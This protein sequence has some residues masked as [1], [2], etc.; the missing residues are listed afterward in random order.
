MH[1][2]D[3]VGLC[4]PSTVKS[5]D[6]YPAL[7]LVISNFPK[8]TSISPSILTINSVAILFHE[9]GYAIHSILGRTP[10]GSFAGTNVMSD[11]LEVSSQMLEEWMGNKDIL[12]QLSSHYETGDHLPDE[13]LDQLI[14]AKKLSKA[15][16]T[17]R[18]I[19]LDRLALAYFEEGP[20]KDLYFIR[21]DLYIEEKLE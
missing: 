7:S 20:V 3:G 10:L 17:Q 11:F 14:A 12:R 4:A 13:L 15:W 1:L 21:D 2:Y 5:D 18:Q 19:F 9:F 16:L 6:N 8:P